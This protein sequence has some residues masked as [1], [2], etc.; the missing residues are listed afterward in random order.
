MDA[1][2]HVQK[3]ALASPLEMLKIVLLCI[4]RYSKTLSRRI[5]YALFS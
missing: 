2:R 4:S 1:C 3:G 5:I